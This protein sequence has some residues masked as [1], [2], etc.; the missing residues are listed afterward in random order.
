ME[1]WQIDFEWLRVRHHVKD[2][3]GQSDLPDL[4][5]ILLLIGVQEANLLKKAYTKEEKQDLMHVA[6][7]QLLSMDGYFEYVGQD[8]EGWPHYKQMRIVPAEGEK[9]QER[10]LKECIIQ[11]FSS[12]SNKQEEVYED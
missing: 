9:A 2:A 6:T 11:Y 7:C 4:Q 8:D 5:I 1:D 3:M 12:S 10:L